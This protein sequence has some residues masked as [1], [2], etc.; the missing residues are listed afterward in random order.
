MKLLIIYINKILFHI[1]LTLA[2]KISKIITVIKFF[3]NNIDFN[4]DFK[5]KGIPY[6]NVSLKGKVSIG[7]KFHFNSG[8]YDNIIGRQQKVIIIVAYDGKLKIGDNVGISSSAIICYK[9]IT[10]EDNVRIGGNC[11][12]YDTDF[13]DMDS[14]NRTSENED[15]SKIVSKSVTIK[16]GAF[17]GAH[18]TILKGVVIGENA[19]VGAGSVVTKSIPENEIWAG[20]PAKF[21]RMISNG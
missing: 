2:Y 17:I 16:K 1:Y 5:A 3:V 18:S 12:I 8:Y 21:I 7:K 13:H 19:V 14:K 4:Y 20:N 6:V 10:I 9:D 11:V 15:R